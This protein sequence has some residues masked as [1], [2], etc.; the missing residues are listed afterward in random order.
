MSKFA[1]L[2]L[3]VFVSGVFAAIWQHAAFAFVLYE[4]VF[5]LNPSDRWWGNELPGISYSFVASVLMLSILAMRYKSLSNK[6]PWLEHPA[7]KWLAL[8]LVSYYLAYLWAKI[9]QAHDNFTFIFA[10]LTII[11]FVAYKLLD[12]EKALDYAIWGYVVGCAY[13]GYLATITGRNSGDRLEGINL[14]QSGDANDVAAVLVPAC[15]LLLYLVWVSSRKV[16]ALCIVFGAF[17]ANALVL[18]NS[19]GAFLGILSSAGLFAMFMIFSRYR[20]KGQRALAVVVVIMGL[21]GALYVTD[22]IFW[23]RMGTLEN[24]ESRESGSGRMKFWVAAV[25]MA[26]EYPLG[27]GVGGF[28]SLA[29]LYLTDEERLGTEFRSVHSLWFQG[30]TEI[31]WHGLAFFVFM[32]WGA[33]KISRLARKRLL[34][35]GEPTTY[36]KVLALECALFGFLVTG[37]FT[38]QFRTEILYWMVL[39]VAVAG[40]VYYLQPLA[41]ERCQNKER[42]PKSV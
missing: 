7:L 38:N 32:L 39:L 27:M 2:F 36:F 18:F 28:N 33:Y 42:G 19:R 16:K 11:I 30:L 21:A 23:E 25:D 40:K 24:L 41:V 12:S 1:L 15:S 35:I 14:P 9:P 26:V 20:Q 8:M 6:S 29:S 5:F 4:L 10:K 3:L 37:T 17:I 13:I 31:G 22:D 34:E